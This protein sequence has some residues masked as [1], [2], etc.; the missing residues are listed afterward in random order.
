MENT[1]CGTRSKK[2]RKKGKPLLIRLSHPGIQ[3]KDALM[4][5]RREKAPEDWG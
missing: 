4:L 1:G 5:E 2:I 3:R